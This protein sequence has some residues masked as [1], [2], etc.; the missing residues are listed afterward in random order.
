M[1]EEKDILLELIRTRF[2]K[3]G[4]GKNTVKTSAEIARYFSQFLDVT[5]EMV[6]TRM[7]QEGY[8]IVDLDGMPYW[9]VKTADGLSEEV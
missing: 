5:A 4:G 7:L 1:K 3:N 9:E 6:T 2:P 8:N